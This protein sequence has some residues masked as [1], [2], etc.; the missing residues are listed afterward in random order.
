LIEKVLKACYCA[1]LDEYLEFRI[2]GRCENAL[3]VDVLLPTNEK[4][5]SCRHRRSE[6]LPLHLFY[7]LVCVSSETSKI[8]TTKAVKHFMCMSSLGSYLCSYMR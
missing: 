1:F 4:L 7:N 5:Q 6:C 3:L 2:I 8:V